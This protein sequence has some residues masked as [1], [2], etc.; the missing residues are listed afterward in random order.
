M[1][2]NKPK[3]SL[4]NRCI[5]T[6]VEMRQPG[7]QF[8]GRKQFDADV[9]AELKQRGVIHEPGFVDWWELVPGAE[10]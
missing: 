4:H 1:T 6:I 9:F 8:R 7:G 5:S 2:V 10:F 3:G